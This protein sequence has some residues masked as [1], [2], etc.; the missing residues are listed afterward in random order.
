[1]Y[2][3]IQGRICAIKECDEQSP[4][5]EKTVARGLATQKGQSLF[6]GFSF[7]RKRDMT[8]ALMISAR[9]F[10]AEGRLFLPQFDVTRAVSPKGA[11]HLGLQLVLLRLDTETPAVAVALSEMVFMPLDS[12]RKDIVLQSALPE[13]E[14]M[15]IGLLYAG[16][17]GE[18]YGELFWRRDWRN[19]LG[20]ISVVV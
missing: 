16:F 17:C 1:M 6:N 9:F 5:G 7:N 18:D 12:E 8:S 11:K 10:L 14:G 3:H 19:S 4:K 20:V 15:L 13:G 2:G